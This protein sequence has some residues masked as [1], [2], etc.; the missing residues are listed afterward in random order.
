MLF[1][2]ILGNVNALIHLGKWFPLGTEYMTVMKE[3]WIH[4]LSFSVNSLTLGGISL[5][6]FLIIFSSLLLDDG[7][8]V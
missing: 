1:R 2:S 7:I 3:T 8:S 6:L 4:G 5:F